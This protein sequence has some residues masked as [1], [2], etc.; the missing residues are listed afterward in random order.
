[1]LSK[2]AEEVGMISDLASDLSELNEILENF[3][4][5]RRN[6]SEQIDKLDQQIQEADAKAA[7]AEQCNKNEGRSDNG[8]ERCL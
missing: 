8:R 4:A 5:M 2:G 7:A 6:V 3:P 1:M